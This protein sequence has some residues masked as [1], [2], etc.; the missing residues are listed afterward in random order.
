M[1]SG[2]AILT[3]IVSFFNWCKTIGTWTVNCFVAAS[4]RVI[5]IVAIIVIAAAAAAT[6][7]IV[8]VHHH[9][10]EAEQFFP[11]CQNILLETDLKDHKCLLIS[12]S[13]T[14]VAPTFTTQV[15]KI[16]TTT[17]NSTTPQLTPITTATTVTPGT[18]ENNK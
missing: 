16:T 6:G 18:L 13:R 7:T 10:G 17:Q 1:T 2:S 4:L 14:S 12:E 9:Q 3:F 5:V 8:Y 15:S 11:K